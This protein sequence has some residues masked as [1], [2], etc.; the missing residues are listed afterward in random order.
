MLISC[1]K[2]NAEDSIK[3]PQLDLPQQVA[4]RETTNYVFSCDSIHVYN[5]YLCSGP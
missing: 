2:R 4:M 5:E 3:E 1:A